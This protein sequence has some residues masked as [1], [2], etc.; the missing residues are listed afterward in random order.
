[1]RLRQ[2]LISIIYPVPR[3][4]TVICPIDNGKIR[5]FGSRFIPARYRECETVQFITKAEY[6]LIRDQVNLQLFKSI[7]GH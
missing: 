3:R 6:D 1:M 5:L 7:V 2:K 4:L